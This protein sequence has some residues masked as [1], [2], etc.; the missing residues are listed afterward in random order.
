MQ[1]ALELPEGA[2]SARLTPAELAKFD[3]PTP[4]LLIDL[5]AVDR[6][7][8]A[9]T[10]ALPHVTVR[11]AVK[12]NPDERILR[13]LQAA[14][15]AFEMAS[16][17]ELQTLI[18]LGVPAEDIIFSSPIKPWKQIRE[19]ARAGVWRFAFDSASELDKLAEYAP[20]A[21][22]YVRLSTSDLG[23]EVPSEGKFG[24]GAGQAIELMQLARSLG[25]KPYGIAYHV[26]SQMTNPTAWEDATRQSAAVLRALEG[27]DIKLSMFNIGGGFP[28]RYADQVPGLSEYGACIRQ[29]IGRH[30]PYSIQLCAEPGR[31]LVAEAGVLV[32]SVIGTAERAGKSWLHLDVGAFNGMMETLLTQNRLVYPLADSRD[33]VDRWPYHITGPTCD[34]QDT[35]FF[36]VSLS[37]GLIP[38]DQVYIYTA[39]AYT[40]CYASTFNGFSLP[41]TYCLP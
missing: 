33:S 10:E 35:M 5:D 23:S 27:H 3:H 19:A 39:G 40:T 18:G 24:V 14:G 9:I 28:A 37:R 20:G 4:Y 7:Y 11:Y 36:G 29:A 15:S 38:G 25:L 22:V 6:A 13:R 21:A 16:Y 8:H 17:P 30:L 41:K 26:G 32:A 2:R 12:C 34:S 31:A 1:T